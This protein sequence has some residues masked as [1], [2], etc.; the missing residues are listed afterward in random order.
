MSFLI[1]FLVEKFENEIELRLY[2]NIKGGKINK[3]YRKRALLSR[4]E[5]KKMSNYFDN[6]DKWSWQ[7]NNKTV[8]VTTD[9]GDHTHTLNLT[10]VPIGE[11]VDHTG[12]VMGDAHRSVS[13]DFKEDNV[14]ESIDND[15]IKNLSENVSGDEVIQTNAMESS[16]EDKV[17]TEAIEEIEE[18]E[19]S[20]DF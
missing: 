7:I 20:L 3:K 2:H 14:V 8:E 15:S 11:M 18:C 17:D 12:Q 9:H 5:K 1:T 19:N 13:H 4:R 10:N 6:Q 16:L